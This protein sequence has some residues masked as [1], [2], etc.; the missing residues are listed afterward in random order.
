MTTQLL[1]KLGIKIV[2]IRNPRILEVPGVGKI[3]SSPGETIADVFE[4]VYELGFN[5]GLE[6]G[7]EQ[8]ANEIKNCLNL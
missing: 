5:A 3:Q 6:K 2:Q 8:K 4:T 7:K 1:E